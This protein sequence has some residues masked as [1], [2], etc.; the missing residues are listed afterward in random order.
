MNKSQENNVASVF[1]ANSLFRLQVANIS[2]STRLFEEHCETIARTS[3][4][5]QGQENH[6]KWS[7]SCS[8]VRGYLILD[9]YSWVLPNQENLPRAKVL[10]DLRA[11]FL[12]S[13]PLP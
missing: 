13:M 4:I 10:T 6:P 12:H 8:L 1:I 3:Y 2:N 5:H 7:R 11:T 9:R